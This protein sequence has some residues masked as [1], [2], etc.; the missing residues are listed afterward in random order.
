[1]RLPPRSIRRVAGPLVLSGIA[2]LGVLL[3]PALLVAAVVASVFLPGKWRAVRLLGFA[4]AW[5]AAEI[6]ALTAAFW[7]WVASGFGRWLDAAWVQRAHYA[8][9]RLVLDAVVD[10][11][12]VILRLDL[13]TDAVSWSPLD[14][15]VPG[16]SNAMLVLSRHGGPGDSLL[17]VQTLMNRDHLRQ[18]RI[19]LKDTL[20]LDP[21]IDTFLHRLPARFV[22]PGSA[23]GAE[24][25]IG[26]LAM[27]MGEGDAL[28]IFP[29][30]GN[31]TPRRRV[32]AIE[33]LRSRGFGA[34]AQAAER[35]R[36]VLPP[37]PGG[38]LAALDA[39]PRADVVFVAHTGLDHLLTMADIWRELP[40][41]KT[42]RLRWWFV[43]AA[44]VPIDRDARIGW[45]YERWAD[46]D[47]WIE[48]NR[49]AL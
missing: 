40:Q 18:P 23:E 44:D 31:F 19:V 45:L 24:T 34:H 32:R 8:V 21:L 41:D 14:D 7:L 26:G 35:M 27:G 13:V 16:S 33:W 17:L 22:N 6:V 38:V 12:Q 49:E 1:M 37:R 43:A 46:I 2:L 29:E 47:T 25:A 3:L 30:G 15:G 5:L 10:A 48:A 42:L 39:A 36:N 11:A 28:L 9:L 20:Q 4:W